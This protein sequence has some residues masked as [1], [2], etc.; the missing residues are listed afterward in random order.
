MS[1]LTYQQK[2]VSSRLRDTL[3]GLSEANDVL[4]KRATKMV[5]ISTSVVAALTSVNMLPKSMTDSGVFEGMALV[6][7]VVLNL[8]LVWIGLRVWGPG[9]AATPG[10]TEFVSL[11]ENFIDAEMSLA[12]DN[13]V[14][15]LLDSVVRSKKWNAEKGEFVL[16]M[17]WTVQIQVVVI[18]I[19]AVVRVFRC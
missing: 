14:K 5:A 11:K 13:S 12:F 15:D 6:A 17:L 4:E 3:D 2:L 1:E 7:I 19:V 9:S 10:G 18:G 16:A 8:V